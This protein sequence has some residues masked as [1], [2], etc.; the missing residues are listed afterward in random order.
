[1]SLMKP[2][3]VEKQTCVVTVAECN[4]DPVVEMLGACDE[5]ADD[6]R[7]SE[8]GGDSVPSS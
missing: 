8:G 2:L 4:P 7:S 3:R 6:V 1:M 5:A